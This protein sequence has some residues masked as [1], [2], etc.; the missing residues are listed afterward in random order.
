[1]YETYGEPIPSSYNRVKEVPDYVLNHVKE[2]SHEEKEY[3]LSAA[4]KANT[5]KVEAKKN[6][7]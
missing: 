7:E 4:V 1:M 6:D 3:A 5:P 2:R